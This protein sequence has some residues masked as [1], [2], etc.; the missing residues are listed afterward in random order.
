M[1]SGEYVCRTAVRRGTPNRC[2]VKRISTIRKSASAEIVPEGI[3]E[4][5][6]TAVPEGNRMAPHR[7]NTYAP[8][9]DIPGIL[10]RIVR[11]PRAMTINSQFEWSCRM[12]WVVLV[13]ASKR[14]M[15]KAEFCKNEF[16]G[17]TDFDF[18]AGDT[19]A[20]QVIIKNILLDTSKRRLR[21]KVCLFSRQICVHICLLIAM[22][23]DLPTA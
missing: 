6:E 12:N 10:F 4:Q 7:V 5:G 17:N 11:Y 2:V 15:P 13:F 19:I 23:D 22:D 21:C 9:A 18:A 8:E 1:L 20:P 3:S 14:S 16:L